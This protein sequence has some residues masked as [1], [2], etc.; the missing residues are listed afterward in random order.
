[1][2]VHDVASIARTVRVAD[3]IVRARPRF[4]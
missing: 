3:A 2:R 4:G 1:V